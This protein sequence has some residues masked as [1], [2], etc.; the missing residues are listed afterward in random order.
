MRGFGRSLGGMIQLESDK[1][2]K[3][4]QAYMHRGGHGERYRLVKCEIVLC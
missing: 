1:N 4:T 3:V 2:M